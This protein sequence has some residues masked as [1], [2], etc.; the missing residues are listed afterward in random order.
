[1]DRAKGNERGPTNQDD[2]IVQLPLIFALAVHL[3]HLLE[4][5]EHRLHDLLVRDVDIL[6]DL[7]RVGVDQLTL[8][9]ADVDREILDEVDDAVSLLAR[10]LCLLHRFNLRVLAI[11]TY[12]SATVANRRKKTGTHNMAIK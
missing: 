9:A 5:I 6:P 2:V 4:R 11:V 3:G 12:P 1:M 8:D 10:Q 7:E